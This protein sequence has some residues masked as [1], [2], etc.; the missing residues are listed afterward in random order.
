VRVFPRRV[1][2][3]A[4][5][6]FPPS[7]FRRKEE[8]AVDILVVGKNDPFYRKRKYGRD[9]KRRGKE[10]GDSSHIVTKW[11][12]PSLRPSKR[13]NE[14]LNVITS[15]ELRKQLSQR[16]HRGLFD[17]NVSKNFWSANYNFREKTSEERQHLKI[18]LKFS[19][20]IILILTWFYLKNSIWNF[21]AKFM[22]KKEHYV[23]Q[24]DG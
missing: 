14:A 18:R 19:F 17:P 8:G 3:V 1:S 11:V 5:L 4:L 16:L 9:G 20:R 7:L 2:P 10:S 15:L 13:L 12:A 23:M 21:F 24:I 22:L 6:T